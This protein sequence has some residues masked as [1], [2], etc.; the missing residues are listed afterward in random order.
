MQLASEVAADEP[1]SSGS[2]DVGTYLRLSL[3][4][5]SPDSKPQSAR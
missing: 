3:P 1:I 4:V 2:Q 5:A